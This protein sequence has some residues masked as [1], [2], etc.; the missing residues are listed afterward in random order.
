MVVGCDDDAD[1]MG[2]KS[3][4]QMQRP[5]CV[6]GDDDDDN[7]QEICRVFREFSSSRSVK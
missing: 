3:E 6:H 7:E 1:G 2:V 4:V 5:G